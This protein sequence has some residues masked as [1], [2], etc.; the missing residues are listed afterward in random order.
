MHMFIRTRSVASKATSPALA[1]ES[2]ELVFKQRLI[3][4]LSLVFG[5]EQQWKFQGHFRSW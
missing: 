4:I 3:I 5:P 1:P 2:V